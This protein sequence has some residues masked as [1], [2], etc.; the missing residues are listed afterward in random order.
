[1]AYSVMVWLVNP[2]YQSHEEE[3]MEWA[4]A[5]RG[6]APGAATGVNIG[7]A[8][9]RMVYGVYE[10]EEEAESALEGISTSLQQNS[11]L[12][13]VAS[14]AGRVFLVPADRV[15]Y[16]VCAQVERPTDRRG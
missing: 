10:T 2:G 15:H 5:R 12:R 7:R 1:M 3:E 16:V 14:H 13:I 11:P 8:F 6:E 9:T 4:T